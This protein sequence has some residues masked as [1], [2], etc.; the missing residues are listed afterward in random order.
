MTVARRGAVDLIVPSAYALLVGFHEGGTAA[1]DLEVVAPV[2]ADHAAAGVRRDTTPDD[3]GPAVIVLPG[4]RRGTAPTTAMD[5]VVPAGRPIV[6]PLDGTV[7]AVE[8]Y[9]LYG[10]HDDVRIVIEPADDPGVVAIVL[11]V[12]DPR[13]AAGDQ[14]R[15]GE[16]VI[17]GSARVLP[18]TS[19]IDR[20]TR[21]SVRED[22]P[23]HVHV[24][25]QR[26]G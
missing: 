19:Q 22:A 1:L 17:A 11:H 12:R 5:V 20:Y 21:R 26:A 8:D 9:L 25:L 2:D 13:V 23:P 6:S 14:L 15:G 10:R 3:D 4:R 24:E 16:T 7:V 18:R